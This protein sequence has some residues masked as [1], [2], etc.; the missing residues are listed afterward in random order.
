MPQSDL[1][2]NLEGFLVGSLWKAASA[3]NGVNMLHH[4]FCDFR[5]GVPSVPNRP[6]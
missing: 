6:R 3:A 2:P 1:L 5:F 4:I